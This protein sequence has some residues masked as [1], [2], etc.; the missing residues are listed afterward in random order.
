MRYIQPSD[1]INLEKVNEY[2]TIC[3]NI[4]YNKALEDFENKIKECCAI[5]GSCDFED[6]VAIKEQLKGARNVC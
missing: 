1:F 5:A 4:A 3:E 6:M 2:V